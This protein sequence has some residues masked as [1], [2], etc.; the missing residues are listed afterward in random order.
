ME[1]ASELSP[2]DQAWKAAY[3][4]N[5][6]GASNPVA[7]AHALAK[8]SSAIMG[9][10]HDTAAVKQHDALRAIAGQL[11]YLYGLALGPSEETLDAVKANAER[12]GCIIPG[13]DY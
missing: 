5:W 10:L 12:I 8:H 3:E 2:V 4:I 7:V 6:V 11:A 13:L 9:E 1:T